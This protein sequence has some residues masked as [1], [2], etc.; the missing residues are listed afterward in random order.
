MKHH[1]ILFPAAFVAAVVFILV[2]AGPLHA[3]LQTVRISAGQIQE[4][5][6]RAAMSQNP[7]PQGTVRVIFSSPAQEMRVQGEKISQEV[8]PVQGNPFLGHGQYA[9]R[10][11]DRGVFLAEQRVSVVIETQRDVVMSARSLSRN[12]RLAPGDIQVVKRWVRRIPTQAVTDADGAVGKMLR[13]NVA[14]HTEITQPMLREI[15][16]VRKGA[17]VRILYESGPMRIVTLGVSEE[18]GQ[19][20]GT[21]RVRNTSSRKILHA[22]VIGDSTV[23]LVF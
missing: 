20:G 15:P 1:T 18:D 6:H 19:D 10:I 5:V 14:P 2:N 21:V 3:A 8:V 22:R 4:A 13:V 7:S 17:P 9:V 12:S 11:Y 23:Q 16:V